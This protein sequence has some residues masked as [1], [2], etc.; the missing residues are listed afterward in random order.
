MDYKVFPPT[1]L[2]IYE[3]GLSR[4]MDTNWLLTLFPQHLNWCISN[5]KIPDGLFWKTKH[6]GIL[7]VF[8]TLFFEQLFAIT[9]D[10]LFCDAYTAYIRSYEVFNL[11]AHSGGENS[12][13]LLELLLCIDELDEILKT[14]PSARV[15]SVFHRQEIHLMLQDALLDVEEYHKKD[16]VA[17]K[18]LYAKN[19]A[20]R[21]LH[22]RQMCEYISFALTEMYNH[23][24]FPIP[25]RSRSKK[26]II[27]RVTR[28]RWPTWVLETLNARERGKCANCSSN[29]L[30]LQSDSHIDHI[31]PL[32]K[33]GSND[34]VNLQLLCASCNLQKSDQ[35]QFVRSSIPE[36]LRR[37]FRSTKK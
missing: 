21:A 23:E 29:F 3:N 17:L 12:K 6:D 24:G 7:Y 34:L 11:I 26:L 13:T 18:N 25:Y 31:V 33:G 2:R 35:T 19:F 5:G 8:G 36:Y 16:V 1:A 15:N 10:V 30:E 32:N 37:P 9:D 4:L 27:K 22:D 28:R 14:V 20:E